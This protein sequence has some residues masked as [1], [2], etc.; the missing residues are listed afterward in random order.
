MFKSNLNGITMIQ[1]QLCCQRGIFT[2]NCN[3]NALFVLKLGAPECEMSNLL[4]SD[5]N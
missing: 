5:V 4:A 2:K 3:S 1:E